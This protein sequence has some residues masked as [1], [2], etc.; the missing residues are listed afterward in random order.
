M[1]PNTALLIANGLLILVTASLVIVTR[2]YT[3]YTKKMADRMHKDHLL[4]LKPSLKVTKGD[5]KGYPEKFERKLILI[6]T[7]NAKK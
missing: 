6:T 4:K 5:I 2:R 3:T 7:L 1:D